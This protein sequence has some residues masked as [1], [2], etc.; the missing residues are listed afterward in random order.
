MSQQTPSHKRTIIHVVIIVLVVAGC[1]WSLV[2]SRDVTAPAEPSADLRTLT[3]QTMGTTYTVKF[4]A[5]PDAASALAGRAETAVGAALALVD[6]RMS[7]WREDSELSRFNR[8]AQSTPF[9][10][11]AE[12]IEVFEIAERVSEA[13]GGAF[14]ITVGPLVNAWGFGP[15]VQTVEGP[16]EEELAE[17]R[18]RVGYRNIEIDA[19]ACT[20]R[21]LR[22]DIYCDL[23]AVAKG[24]GVDRVA[25]ALEQLGIDDY[26]VEVGGEVRTKG[27]KNGLTWRIAVERPVLGGRAVQKI[28]EMPAGGRAMATSGDYRNYR[29]V[30]GVRVCHTVDPRTGRPI[31]HKLASVTVLDDTCA[32]ADAYATA[33]MVLGPETGYEL[34]SKLELAALLVI[35]EAPNTFSEKRTPAF[36]KLDG[37]GGL[38]S[39]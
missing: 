11:S 12:T 7:T 39:R 27:T 21:K 30:D 34:A 5:P 38:V 33:I 19:A 29:E 22:P 36:A 17:L 35:R 28:L 25:D 16:S 9:A 37:G 2:R 14:D 26:M 15:D 6:E 3:G 13:S 8:F 20:L 1:L 18:E 10:V 24:Y 23:G 31:T 4:V 32:M